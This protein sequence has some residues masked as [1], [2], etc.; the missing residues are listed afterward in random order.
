MDVVFD[1]Y[2]FCLC[3]QGAKKVI[4]TACHSGKLKLTFT[5]ANIFSTSSK[6]VFDEQN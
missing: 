6:N 1:A 4:F 5:S 3:C 2:S